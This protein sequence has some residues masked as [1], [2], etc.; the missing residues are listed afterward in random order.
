MAFNLFL[1]FT[2]SYFLHFTS[3][4]PILAVI[5]F[6][7]ILY[8]IL[9]LLAL[10]GK[11]G[12]ESA[13]KDRITKA[14]FL[15]FACAMVSVPFAMW[16][17]SVLRFGLQNFLK[18]V[19]FFFYIVSFIKTE[20]QLKLFV[21]VLL[22][23]QVFRGLEPLYLHIS[24]GYWGS[25]DYLGKGEFMDRLAGAPHDIVNPN[26]LAWV[27]VSTIPFLYYFGLR[28]S[29]NIKI[30][31]VGV[32]VLLLYSMI[33]TGSRSGLVSLQ[34]IIIAISLQGEGRLKR[35]FYVAVIGIPL[36]FMVAGNLDYNTSQRYLSLI[37]SSAQG[38]KGVQGRINGIK[39]NLS[40]VY[41]IH[42]LLGHGLGTSV[43]VNSYYLGSTQPS[44]NLYIETIQEVGLIGSLF[45]F[46]YIFSIIQTLIHVK[47]HFNGE[48]KLGSF[49]STLAMSIFVW[50]IMDLIY[51]I[52]CFGLTS[53][54]WYLFGGLVAVCERLILNE[55]PL[56]VEG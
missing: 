31:L 51:S 41:N 29:F 12:L 6:D 16:P 38:A 36:T 7:L 34:V 24:T 55:N 15:F 18:S 14:L 28:R 3:R 39:N 27:I 5:R 52:S 49:I 19:L 56:R 44:H 42:G 25:S 4:I 53:W 33:L 47:V 2:V 23:C 11:Q 10:L 50:V 54:E 21:F 40:T 37:D 32:S 9:A 8:A 43:E 13:G 1:L 45:F 26:Q 46:R 48:N 22:F 30:L 17:G 20:K 35:V